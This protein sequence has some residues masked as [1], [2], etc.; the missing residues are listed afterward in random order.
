MAL[1]ALLA[2]VP[3]FAGPSA[4]PG[5]HG[6]AVPSVPVAG[7]PPCRDR[8]LSPFGPGSLWNVAIGSGAQ[9]VPA[10][11]YRQQQALDPGPSPVQ[12]ANMTKNVAQRRTCPGAFAGITAAQCAAKGCCFSTVH[13][14]VP[15]PWCFNPTGARALGP[16]SFHNDADHF[17]HV[18]VTDP[19]ITWWMQGGWGPVPP[20]GR[21][22]VQPGTR[23]FT[24][25]KI[26]LPNFLK[27]LNSGCNGFD[28]VLL[29]CFSPLAST[30]RCSDRAPPCDRHCRLLN[31]SC[32]AVC[33]PAML[34]RD[35]GCA[36]DRELQQRAVHAAAGQPD[37]DPDAAGA[38]VRRGRPAVLADQRLGAARRRRPPDVRDNCGSHP[39]DRLM[40]RLS[41]WRSR[42]N[43]GAVSPSRMRVP[44][45]ERSRWADGCPALCFDIFDVRP[46]TR[47]PSTSP[48]PGTTASTLR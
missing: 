11:L 32:H 35:C 6:H 34:C 23:P 41:G 27:E 48:R 9:F 46:G 16:G 42:R 21:C 7:P 19:E 26:R 15:C 29:R 38:A 2:L 22:A 10:D 25:G 30:Q 5:T 36:Q 43:G 8:F 47:W 14:D 12:C 3:A 39:F 28:I 33:F 18:K 45:A 13:C 20:G 44:W 17:V 24:L 40:T 4:L 37:R 31:V 1:G